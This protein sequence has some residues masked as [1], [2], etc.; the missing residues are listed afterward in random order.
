MCRPVKVKINYN[1]YNKC[2]IVLQIVKDIAKEL[3]KEVIDELSLDLSQ[4]VVHALKLLVELTGETYL[5]I[6]KDA[7]TEMIKLV[8]VS[9]LF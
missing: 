1:L 9:L 7:S 3:F 6:F 8:K 2:L 5:S 4:Q